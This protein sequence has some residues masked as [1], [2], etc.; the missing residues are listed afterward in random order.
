MNEGKDIKT[1]AGTL[2]L[3]LVRGDSGS[4]NADVHRKA[5][6]NDGQAELAAGGFASKFVRTLDT[7]ILLGLDPQRLYRDHG[8]M[9]EKES[10][11]EDGIDVGIIATP[12]YHHYP[13]AIAFLQRGI[14]VVCD[15][16]LTLQ[17]EEAEE[18]AS[19]AEEKGLLFCVTYA[20]SSIPRLSRPR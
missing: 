10:A 2:R 9:A 4:Y 7:V 15:K 8:E 18:L 19:L 20:Y 3:G 1:Q 6:L 13:A 12:N 5:A 17:V 11:R 16:P 14:H